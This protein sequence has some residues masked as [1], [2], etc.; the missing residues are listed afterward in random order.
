MLW[1]LAFFNL[2]V[3]FGITESVLS[4]CYQKS[5]PPRLKQLDAY[6]RVALLYT[7]F[8]DLF[9]PALNQLS[10]QSYPNYD[11]FILDDSTEET[12]QKRIDPFGQ[13]Y[14]IVRRCSRAGAKAGNLNNWLKQYGRQY[15]YF[16][17]LDNDSIIKDDFIETLM[18]YAQHPENKKSAIFQSLMEIWKPASRFAR[19]INVE[20]IISNYTA[21]RLYNRL[22]FYLGWGHNAL[23]NTQAVLSI[24]GF[25]ETMVGEDINLGLRL[26][27]EGY[28]LKLV[29]VLSYEGLPDGVYKFARRDG[30]ISQ[31][32]LQVL[33]S[34][35]WKIPFFTCFFLFIINLNKMSRLLVVLLNFYFLG[36]GFYYYV[37]PLINQLY[38]KY[39]SFKFLGCNLSLFGIYFLLPIGLGALSGR[40]TG[41]SLKETVKS[42]IIWIAYD[43]GVCFYIAQK[44]LSYLLF[45]TVQFKV[46]NQKTHGVKNRFLYYFSVFYFSAILCIV[47]AISP[48][49]AMIKLPWIICFL[50]LFLV[51]IWIFF[52]DKKHEI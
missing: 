51:N 49:L 7:T 15:P 30:R 21:I 24:E 25:D 3:S 52:G 18:C 1:I 22:G 10:S 28:E 37:G 8:D 16:V 48:S 20:K 34:S 46:T 41:I 9:L 19:A 42:R 29:D 12:C 6:P 45:R 32:N 27:E 39:N 40:K 36:V 26:I 38:V 31:S 5:E 47:A 11:V 33:F 35:N 44:V 23:F 43:V 4:F 2:L 50:I 17:I 14:T 13:H